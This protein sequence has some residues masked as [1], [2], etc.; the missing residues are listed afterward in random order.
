MKNIKINKLI[1]I[2]MAGS[3]LLTLAAGCAVSETNGSESAAEAVLSAADDND[4]DITYDREDS[5]VIDISE[6]TDVTISEGGTFII[7]GE[8]SDGSI[9]VDAGDEEVQLVLR[10]VSLTC[11]DSSA[12]TVLSSGGVS[13]ILEGNNYLANGGQFVNDSDEAIDAVV[14][15]KDDLTVSGEGSLEISSPAGH[16]IVC[17]DEMAIAGGTYVIEALEDGINTNDAL[18]IT[19]G[20]FEINA[21]DDAIHTD[22]IISITGGTFDITAAEGLEGTE[23]VIDGGEITIAATDDG[24]N[25]AQKTDNVA[26]YVEINGGNIT[27]TMG[28][29]DTD[30][31]DSNGDITITGGTIDITGMSTI[32]YDGTATFTGG[33]LIVNGSQTDTIPNQETGDGMAPGGGTLGEGEKP[34]EPPAG[35]VP[36]AQGQPPAGDPPQ[37]GFPG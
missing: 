23:I 19:D 18:L 20:I 5:Q 15:S 9:T 32:D 8:T 12:I 6:K 21:G 35:E 27:I 2:V 37:G 10:D 36:V 34:G 26:V 3:L 7:T 1:P 33:T 30:G 29:G 4:P 31:I 16:G 14:Y 24:I 22:G 13:V 28:Q 17:K 25:A 11:S